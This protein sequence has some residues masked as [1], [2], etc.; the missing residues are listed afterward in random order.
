M[1]SKLGSIVLTF[2]YTSSQPLSAAAIRFSVLLGSAKMGQ[3]L[4]SIRRRRIL[5][6]V[7]LPD[8]CLTFKTRIGDGPTGRSAAVADAVKAGW[9]LASE[10]NEPDFDALRPGRFPEAGGRGGVEGRPK[11][12][13]KRLIAPIDG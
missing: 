8:D 10:P 11:S 1:Q 9:A 5:A 13:A 12:Q 4:G 6:S 2:S 7:L 3:V